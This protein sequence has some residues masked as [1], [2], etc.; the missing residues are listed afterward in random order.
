MTKMAGPDSKAKKK[1]SIPDGPGGASAPVEKIGTFASL[2][3]H[4]FRLLL[5]GTTLSNAAQ[6]IQHVALSWLVYNLTGSGTILGTINMVRS[7]ASLAMTPMAGVLIDRLNRRSI[8]LI[9]NGWLFSITSALGLMLILGHSNISYLFVFTFLAG[10]V[11]TV[12]FSL[13]QVLVFDLVPRSLTPNGVALVQTGWSLMRSFGPGIG[14]L[15]ILWF[16]PGGNFLIQAGVYVLIA[17]TIMQISFPVRTSGGIQG[18]SLDN[19]REGI[20]YIMKEPTTKAFMMMG[21]VLPLLI[22]PIFVILPPIYAVEVFGDGS[23]KILG[24]LMAS[25]GVGGIAG[26]F[27]TASLGHLERRGLLQIAS[28]F[29]LSLSLIGFAF[30]TTLLISL[31]LLA[32]A[33]FFEMIFLTTN[34]TL[35]QLSIPDNLRGRVTTI[36]N[37]NFALMPLGGLVAGVGSDLL[38]G[39]KMITIILAGIAAIIAFLVLLCSPTIRNYRLSEAIALDWPS[40]PSPTIEVV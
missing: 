28:L 23:G 5:T 9:E 40:T 21:L 15:L 34:Q 12:D 39:P 1:S 30:S 14:G 8:L 31:A 26:G 25:V 27:V 4:N 11:H 17:I 19:I 2:R 22:I 24:F 7:V 16:G 13:R 10:M 29:L 3:I 37:L 33:G 38:G 18:F 35:I 36:V 20:R 32:F 6:W